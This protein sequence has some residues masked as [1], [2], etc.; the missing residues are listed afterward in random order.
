LFDH[1][2]T[3]NLLRRHPLAT[4]FRLTFL[5][6]Q[7][8]VNEL[9][10]L[11]ESVEHA[12]HRCELARPNVVRRRRD[13]AQLFDYFSTHRRSRFS[14][15]VWRFT[16]KTWTPMFLFPSAAELFGRKF[17]RLTFRDEN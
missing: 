12:A 1:H 10:R 14:W 11:R 2:R 8:D 16:V 7:V 17:R 6:D 5:V 3:E 9:K 4:R 13:K 15:W